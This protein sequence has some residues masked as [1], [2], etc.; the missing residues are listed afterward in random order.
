MTRSLHC[1][2]LVSSLA[3]AACSDPVSVGT[4]REDS[5]RTAL[6]DVGAA[7]TEGATRDCAEE[8]LVAPCSA[9]TQ[10]CRGGSWSSCEGAVGP[11]AEVCDNGID[12]DCNGAVDDAASC[13][14]GPGD[15]GV[16]DAGA[17]VCGARYHALGGVCVG[18]G[19]VRP[20]TPTST[21]DTTLRRPTLRFELPD[22]ADGA[23]VELSLFSDHSS[24]LETLRVTGTSAR[25]SSALPA[26]SLVYWRARARVG[27]TE[28]TAAHYGPT[29]FF[30]TPARD[31]VDRARTTS[32]PIDSS[33]T[34]HLSIGGP[35]MLAVGAPSYPIFRPGNVYVFEGSTLGLTRVLE[36]PPLEERFG[37]SVATAGDVNGDGLGDL[38]VLAGGAK[39]ASRVYVYHGTRTGLERFESPPARVL[40]GGV[41][42]E[43]R[44]ESIA[45][46]G[47]V[48]ADGFADILIG[49]PGS[50]AVYV[51][52]GRSDG[53]PAEPWVMIAGA[54][55]D[56]F[57]GDVAGAGDVNGDGF[58]DIV[59]GASSR[60]QASVL[61]GSADGLIN[62]Q[63]L[64]GADGGQFGFAVA[65]AGDVN[66]DGY[67]DIIVGAD[68]ANVR[69][70]RGAGTASVYHGGRS[71][72]E[73]APS[74]VLELAGAQESDLFGAAVAGAGDIN[75][76]GFSDVVVGAPAAGTQG[77]CAVHL[78][79]DRGVSAAALLILEGEAVDEYGN[80]GASV[81][82]GDFD[83]DG[84]SD[85]AIAS[86]TS[87]HWG[88]INVGRAN[89]YSG[90]PEGIAVTRS[91]VLRPAEPP[92]GS[93]EGGFYFGSLAS[94]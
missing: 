9:G 85:V 47:D 38:L 28:D 8:F 21:G 1:L 35:H 45:G 90:A 42:W 83:G 84:Y 41:R 44:F 40:T 88:L 94:R 10:T 65:G 52:L 80:L 4:R 33:F 26:S 86:P 91:Q 87:S 27:A 72:I 54:S 53:V 71:G 22:G 93:W 74:R 13:G 68:T 12:D 64:E 67:A 25:P 2:V 61:Y 82:G 39:S 31:V 63:V 7:C 57:G 60:G 73:G 20:I 75:G 48:N 55:G 5:G 46:A 43:S 16:F 32:E 19:G 30:H 76:D 89:V 62:L 78:G 6:D 56:D 81:T 34:P 3:A 24:V 11:T 58:A 51:Y 23:V 14:A 18:D 70:L 69:G 50:N 92:V 49:V 79:G 66:G 17:G 29:W 36:S 77:R 15:A 37:R 59:V